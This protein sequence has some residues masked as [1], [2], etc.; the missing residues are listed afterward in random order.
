VGSNPLRVIYV[1]F[2]ILA[3]RGLYVVMRMSF[4]VRGSEK[5]RI[6]NDRT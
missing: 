2:L 1:F 5:D 6:G 3:R 4:A